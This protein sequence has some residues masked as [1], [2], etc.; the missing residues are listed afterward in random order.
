MIILIQNFFAVWLWI[1]KALMITS[2]NIF[3]LQVSFHID[4]VSNKWEKI[5]FTVQIQEI[6]LEAPHNEEDEVK[7]RTANS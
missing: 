3:L 6:R 1:Y 4:E 7:C 5:Y 2:S